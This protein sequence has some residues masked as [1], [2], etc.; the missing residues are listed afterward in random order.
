MQGVGKAG[1][2]QDQAIREHL[3]TLG[4]AASDSSDTGCE[5]SGSGEVVQRI[6]LA[7]PAGGFSGAS[8]GHL[9]EDSEHLGSQT[10]AM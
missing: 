4:R 10:A 5:F 2:N 3:C 9:H 6:S 7:L 8:D 1:V